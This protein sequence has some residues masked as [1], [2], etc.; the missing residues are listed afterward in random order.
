VVILDCDQ[1]LFSR[2]DHY[3]LALFH[4]L[5]FDLL[6]LSPTGYSNIEQVFKPEYYQTHHFETVNYTLDYD[7]LCKMQQKKKKI[8]LN[9]LFKHK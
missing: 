3:R 1:Q 9:Q 2:N 4:Q 6:I 8:G 7:Q 5:G